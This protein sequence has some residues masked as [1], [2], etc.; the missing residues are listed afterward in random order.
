[1]IQNTGQRKGL[2]QQARGVKEPV[3]PDKYR[4]GSVA[5]TGASL[6]PPRPD[7]SA[8]RAETEN[9]QFLGQMNEF[10]FG[11]GMVMD[12]YGESERERGIAEFERANAE[13]RES[14]KNAIDNG[15]IDSKES[16]YFREGVT[17]SYTKN[18]LNKTSV[19][20]LTEYEKWEGKND[21]SPGAFDN[22]LQEQDEKIA[23]NLESI[24]NKT[25]AKHFFEPHQAIKRQLAQTHS[26]YL[27]KEYRDKANDE[28]DLEMYG[29]LKM[30]GEPLGI[31]LDKQP[32]SKVPEILE[33]EGYNERNARE[34]SRIMSRAD[35]HG[36]LKPSDLSELEAKAFQDGPESIASKTYK[37][38][39]GLKAQE[40]VPLLQKDLW[41]EEYQTE[42]FVKAVV[43]SESMPEY[44]SKY[45]RYRGENL[46]PQLRSE[47]KKQTESF[48]K[49]IKS[50]TTRKPKLKEPSKKKTTLTNETQSLL[51]PKKKH[52]PQKT[53]IMFS[54]G[55]TL[56]K[57][58]KKYKITNWR[59]LAKFLNDTQQ[60]TLN[61]RSE[62][63]SWSGKGFDLN[64]YK[65]W[66]KEN[67][68]N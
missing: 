9:A 11:K 23:I 37:S 34:V 27:N 10:L 62:I 39:T 13:Q 46:P 61:E 14:F 45:S 58:S 59:N 49:V 43:E 29:F 67:N 20:L 47:V 6:Q 26:G 55:D 33:T 63:S 2:L 53:K 52:I 38:L 32:R 8:G 1:M 60:G 50:K 51:N 42:D 65:K 57:L 17:N 31:S 18:L 22:W 66:E 4:R 7:P 68:A 25:L 35:K 36:K 24:P 41:R 40:T 28:A 19:S 30:Y 12:Q 21:P 64:E 3:R 5:N 15:W 16:P 56:I 44:R 54:K 48:R